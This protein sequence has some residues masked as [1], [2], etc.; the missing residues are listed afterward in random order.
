MMNDMKL[1]ILRL[2]LVTHL[3]LIKKLPT[4]Y[5]KLLSENDGN[6]LYR[7]VIVLLMAVTLHYNELPSSLLF[8]LI[9]VFSNYEYLQ[10]Q[11]VLNVI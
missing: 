7:T 10:R 3:V 4:E 5:L 1:F 6:I 9:L 2:V 11:K 8:G